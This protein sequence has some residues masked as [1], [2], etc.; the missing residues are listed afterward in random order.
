MPGRFGICRRFDAVFRQ[1]GD[2]A[3]FKRGNDVADAGFAP[4]EINHRINDQLPGPVIG[5]LPAPV[6]LDDGDV[7]PN[8]Q[9]LGFSRQSLRK[10]GRVFDDPQFVFGVCIPSGIKGFHRFKSRQIFDQTFVYDFHLKVP[11]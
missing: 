1:C 3:V 6:D 11:L 5:N 7:V 4:F 10:D 2:D 8:Q 9:V